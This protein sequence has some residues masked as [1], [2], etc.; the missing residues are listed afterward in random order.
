MIRQLQVLS[1]PA[2]TLLD[3]LI[4]RA[5]FVRDIGYDI[6]RLDSLGPG[7]RRGFSPLGQIAEAGNNENPK[8][9]VSTGGPRR[10]LPRLQAT[11]KS[12]FCSAVSEGEVLEN[13]GY[14]PLPFRVPDE[15]KR[16]EA[17]GLIGN[18]VR[19]SSEGRFHM[20]CCVTSR[21]E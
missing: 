12:D 16:T 10:R 18:Q 7:S 5:D 14:T 3:R 9:I 17:P 19:Q 4:H 21:L 11:V 2:F 1:E 8:A 15:I 6:I 13:L 20:K